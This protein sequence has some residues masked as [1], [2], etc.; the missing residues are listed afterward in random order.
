MLLV[1]LSSS[2]AAEEQVH[3]LQ[4][5]ETI[6]T[7]ARR[8]EVSAEE[9]LRYNEIVDPTRL[10]VGARIRIPNTYVVRPGDYVYSIAQRLGVGWLTLLEVNGLGRNDVVRPGDVLIIPRTASVATPGVTA[11]GSSTTAVPQ[12]DRSGGAP[13]TP[14]GGTLVT[15]TPSAQPVARVE[16]PHPENART[17]PASFPGS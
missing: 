14:D 9:L 11:G 17:G 13:S 10:P 4:R 8:Y 5:G 16:W 3:V 15:T 1:M 12:T 7:L 6:F 2:V